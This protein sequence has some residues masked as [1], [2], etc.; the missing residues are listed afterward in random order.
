MKFLPNDTT[1]TPEEVVTAWDK[2]ETVWSIEMG[3]IG[4]GYEQAIQ[5]LVIELL[6][7]HL[8]K[9]LPDEKDFEKWGKATISRINED[10][11]GFS[12][13]QVGAAKTI[14]WRIFRD[15]YG[16]TLR[17]APK[18]RLIQVSA[19]WPRAGRRKENS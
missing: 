16:P 10:C 2:G 5:V 4:P 11:Y 8:G 17:S 14:A 18:D 9:P 3:G 7:D 12:G 15:G 1:A 19:I 6:R 13:A